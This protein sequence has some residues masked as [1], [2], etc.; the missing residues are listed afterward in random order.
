MVNSHLNP[1]LGTLPVDAPE[2]PNNVLDMFSLKGK[3][4]SVTGSSRGIG[5]AVVE[6][7]CQAGAD[8]AMWYNSLP[9]EDIASELSLKYNVKVIAYQCDVTRYDQVKSV[10][11]QQ[12]KDFGTIDIFVANA[13]VPWI[14]GKLNEIDEDKSEIGWN[15]QITTNLN[16][17]Y[18]CAKTIGPIFEQKWKL[19]GKKSSFIITGSMSG[20]IVN[21]P[22]F[23]AGYNTVKAGLQH[24]SKSLA[25][26]WG[27][28][29]RSNVVNPGYT[30]T[31]ISKFV[32]QNTRQHW[33]TL[34]PMGRE[35]ETKELWGAYLYLAS[36]AS[37]YV[38]GIDIRVDGGYAA[39]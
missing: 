32:D 11:G 19:T 6:C 18:Y 20:Q 38:T 34:I 29:A 15:E 9:A 14:L 13:G 25:V 23:Q 2:L 28:F 26:E 30:L 24:F 7:Y 39:P 35:A 22:Q 5:L 36:D 12:M 10:I 1:A 3:V 31:E 8:V 33:Y 37:S 4:A 21:V 16:S 27:P 17:V